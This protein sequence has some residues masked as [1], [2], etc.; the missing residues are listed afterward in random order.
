MLPVHR[1]A[2]RRPVWSSPALHDGTTCAVDFNRSFN[3]HGG[4]LGYWNR[5]ARATPALE[6]GRSKLAPPTGCSAA[7]SFY[8]L[9][10]PAG[11]SQSQPGNATHLR[12]MEK[13]ARVR[14][15][16]PLVQVA[17]VP[18]RAQRGNIKSPGDVSDGMRTV[19]R[20]LRDAMEPAQ[21]DRLF[22]R[23]LDGRLAQDMVDHGV[24]RLLARQGPVQDLCKNMNHG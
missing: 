20:H 22:D 11:A 4:G 8:S 12:A 16:A 14:R 15:E 10:Q 9:G 6:V 3:P 5:T 19:D 1:D 18:V 21:S 24:P 23:N 13:A 17:I 7:S 2:S